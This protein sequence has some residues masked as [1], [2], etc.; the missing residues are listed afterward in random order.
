MTL[1]VREKHP[2]YMITEV[3][4]EPLLLNNPYKI[5]LI[6]YNPSVRD[7]PFVIDHYELSRQK[8]THQQYIDRFFPKHMPLIVVHE[9][10][11]LRIHLRHRVM[12]D[13][14]Y[15]KEVKTKPYKIIYID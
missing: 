11:V 14:T 4:Y 1:F 7:I 6:Q 5:K 8:L 10:Q 9:D 13:L 2:K 15:N 12:S 3:T